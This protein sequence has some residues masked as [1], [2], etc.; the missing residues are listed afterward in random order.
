VVHVIG[1]YRRPHD[2]YEAQHFVINS[3]AEH[4]SK[5]ILLDL[6][7]AEVIAGTISTFE[8]ANPPA[9]VALE[10]KKFSF[11]ALYPEITENDRFFETV[12]TN[13]GLR[14]RAFDKRE[15]AIKWLENE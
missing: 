10:L 2:G 11:A 5:R 13:R 14:V 12:S 1:E 8:T 15:E 6:T 3:F 4:G 7:Q 9:D